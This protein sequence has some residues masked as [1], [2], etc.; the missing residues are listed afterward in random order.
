MVTLNRE[1]ERAKRWI[2]SYNKSYFY[3]VKQFYCNPSQFKINAEM[4]CINRMVKMD[5]KNYRV[6]G[7]NSSFFTCGYMSKN[8][9][10]LFIETHCNTFAIPLH[11]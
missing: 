11:D 7:G 6:L 10:T 4:D 5:G 9:D 3:S 8:E 2:N 1:T